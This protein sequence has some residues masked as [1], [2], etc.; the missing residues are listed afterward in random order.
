MTHRRIRI[1]Q[2]FYKRRQGYCEQ[3][4]YNSPQPS[5]EEESDGR[6]DGPNVQS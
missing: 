3:E 1:N 4:S 6:C 5:P 2:K